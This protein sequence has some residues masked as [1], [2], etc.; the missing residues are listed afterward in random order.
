MLRGKGI[1]IG[2][3]SWVWSGLKD[4]E[5]LKQARYALRLFV[6]VDIQG[7]SRNRNGQFLECQQQKKQQKRSYTKFYLIFKN[8]K[9]LCKPNLGLGVLVTAS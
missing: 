3:V 9:E 7:I 6:P 8:V 4:R 1:A 5:L 2:R